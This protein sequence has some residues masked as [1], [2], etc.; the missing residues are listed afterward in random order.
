MKDNILIVSR[1][2]NYQ[3]YLTRW[4]AIGTNG[5]GSSDLA[6]RPPGFALLNDNTTITAPFIEAYESNMTEIFGRTGIIV[7]NVSMAMPHVGVV[8]ASSDP[9][10]GIMQPEDLDGLG[11]YSVRAS[12]P[13][14]VVRTLCI[15]ANASDL[16]PFIYDTWE[17]AEKPVNVTIWPDQLA[18][19]DPF[20]NGT[21]YDDIFQWGEA[22]GSSKWPPVF[23]KLPSNYNVCKFQACHALNL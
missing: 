2:H 19:S 12:V 1:Y 14:P 7:N 17:D 18:Y 4:A 13:S 20:L 23:P 21:K 9:I 22:Y 10:N 8:Q 3:Q 16:A 11:I 6:T 15:S 5:T